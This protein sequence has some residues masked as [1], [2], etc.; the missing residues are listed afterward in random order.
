MKQ[1]FTLVELLI[2]VLIIGILSAVALP[3]YTLS[4][5]RS[6][7]AEAMINGKAIMDGIQRAKQLNPGVAVTSSAQIADVT[8]SGSV[9]ADHATWHDNVFKTKNFKYTLGT[10]SVSMER[11]NNGE[12]NLLYT[13]TFTYNDVTGGA[14]HSCSQA[15]G[16]T[17]YDKVCASINKM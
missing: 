10:D 14:T 8:L 15:N 6:R 13:V 3:E 11:R 4:V 17:A 7:S 1:G 5:E 12:G 2:V 16:V 9:D